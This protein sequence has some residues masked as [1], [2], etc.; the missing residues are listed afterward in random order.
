MSSNSDRLVSVR[1]KW[2]CSKRSHLSDSLALCDRG[3]DDELIRLSKSLKHD[4]KGPD[5]VERCRSVHVG[6]MT[7]RTERKLLKN[8]KHEGNTDAHNIY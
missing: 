6:C 8:Q 2:F 7:E 3:G 1:G 4:A 5:T